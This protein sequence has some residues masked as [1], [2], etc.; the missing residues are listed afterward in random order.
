LVS[1]IDY[2]WI[3]FLRFRNRV[4]HSQREGRNQNP[5]CR[6][7]KCFR[8]GGSEELGEADPRISGWRFEITSRPIIAHSL[9][10]YMATTKIVDSSIP[11]PIAFYEFQGERERKQ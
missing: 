2:V 7:K 5:S 10:R 4:I 1:I 6:G 3:G 8:K 11:I 9:V